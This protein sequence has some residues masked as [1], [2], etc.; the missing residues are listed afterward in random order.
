M[1]SETVQF[2]RAVML[3]LCLC[4]PGAADVAASGAAE[5]EFPQFSPSTPPRPAPDLTLKTRSGELVQLGD[6]RGRP[7]LLNIWAT[8][9]VPCVA[10]MP[11]LEALAAERAG[12]PLAIMAVSVDRKGESVVA[13]FVQKFKLAKL[14]IYLDPE[15]N[16]PHAFGV[17]ALPTTILID[18]GGREIGRFLGPVPWDGPAARRLID[19]LLAPKPPE[20]WSAQR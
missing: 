2:A 12:T 10:E 8:W 20:T 17:D 1:E 18:R 19:R 14:P 5:P 16:A 6:F 4:L 7:V 9:C 3:V 15:S 13:P 11:S